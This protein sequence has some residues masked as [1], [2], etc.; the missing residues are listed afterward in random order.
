MALNVILICLVAVSTL[1]AL[2]IY[3]LYGRSA[4]LVIFMEVV[5][6]ATTDIGNAIKR[7]NP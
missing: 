3:D 7:S 1:N 6:K 4:R 2:L 5:R